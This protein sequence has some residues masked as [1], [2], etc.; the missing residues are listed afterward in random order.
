MI[1]DITITN[2][3][4]MEEAIP[5]PIPWRIAGAVPFSAF[6]HILFTYYPSG[7]DISRVNS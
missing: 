7:D 2:I 5:I 1:T 4:T 6:E 3:G